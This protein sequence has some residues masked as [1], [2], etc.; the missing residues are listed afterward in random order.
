M[1]SPET[2]DQ[3]VSQWRDWFWT[4]RQYLA[5]VDLKYKADIDLILKDPSVPVDFDTLDLEKQRRSLFLH[6]FLSSLLKGRSLTILLNV[7]DNHGFEVLRNLVQT[8]QPSS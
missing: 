2:R 3:E 4:V 7:G 8:F 1:F 6:S 5:A